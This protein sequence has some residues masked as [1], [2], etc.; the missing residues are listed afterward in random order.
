MNVSTNDLKNGMTL[1]LPEGLDKASL[2]QAMEGH[3]VDQGELMGTYQ[4]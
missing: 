1:D 4:R 2:L 3:I